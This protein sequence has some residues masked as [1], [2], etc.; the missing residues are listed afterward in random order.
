MIGAFGVRSEDIL[1]D[2]Y[3]KGVGIEHSHAGDLGPNERQR[4]IADEAISEGFVSAKRLADSF[5]VSVMTIYRD[6]EEL[7]ERRIVRR[8][9]GGATAQPSSLFESDVRYRILRFRAEKKALCARALEEIESG[10]A[11]MMDDS[12]TA[13]PL[14]KLAQRLAP[15]TMMTHFRMSLDQ[16]IG[17]KGVK[18]FCLGGEYLDTHDSYVGLGCE[19]AISAVRPDVL[20]ISTS[21]ASEGVAFHQEEEM[22]RIKRAMMSVAQKKILLLDHSKFDRRAFLHLAPLTEFDLVLTD[23]GTSQNALSEMDRHGVTYEVVDTEAYDAK[24]P[25]SPPE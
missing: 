19:R 15:L 25:E 21:A 6:L 17:A 1:S 10:Q 7:Q 5:G 13:L 24:T 14:A 8:E 2:G 4:R 11:V 18:I 3:N 16:M 22:V 12:T 9:R 23:S 20:F